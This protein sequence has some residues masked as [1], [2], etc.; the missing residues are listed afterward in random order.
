[1]QAMGEE[2]LAMGIVACMGHDDCGLYAL[3]WRLCTKITRKQLVFWIN[4]ITVM[5]GQRC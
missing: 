5:F 1:M 2:A 4:R 3:G